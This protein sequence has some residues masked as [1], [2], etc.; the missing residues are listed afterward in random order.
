MSSSTF[1]TGAM[2][3]LYASVGLHLYSIDQGVASANLNFSANL[4][5]GWLPSVIFMRNTENQ[6]GFSKI[7]AIVSVR[8][9]EG[10]PVEFQVMYNTRFSKGLAAINA[11]TP[12]I[13]E[14]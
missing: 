6:G 10:M 8:S 5:G 11:P 9:R 7:Q 3:S 2:S 13:H 12:R 14:C 1:R 4:K